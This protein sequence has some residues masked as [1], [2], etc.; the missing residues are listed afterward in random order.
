MTY[1]RTHT[2]TPV[3]SLPNYH[4]QRW[5]QH[6]LLGNHE[7]A[8]ATTLLHR[9]PQLIEMLSVS[10]S[11]S[12]WGQSLIFRLCPSSLNGLLLPYC[13]SLLSGQWSTPPYLVMWLLFA[14]IRLWKS[15]VVI[16]ANM[17]YMFCWACV[18]SAA[19]LMFIAKL[20]ASRPH[21]CPIYV[22]VD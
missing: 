10:I 16:M 18:K 8:T 6:E 3:M 12:I 15:S 2:Y 5:N 1:I 13:L 20:E 9:Y 14:V 17:Q 11:T 22:G 21:I 4:I 19:L 7:N